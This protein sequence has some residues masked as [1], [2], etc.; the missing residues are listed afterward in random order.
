MSYFRTGILMQANKYKTFFF[1]LHRVIIVRCIEGICLL[2]LEIQ[3]SPLS[4][5]IFRALHPTSYAGISRPQTLVQPRHSLASHIH[6]NSLFPITFTQ[7]FNPC[8]TLPS[9]RKPSRSIST[10]LYFIAFEFPRSQQQASFRVP[11]DLA[12]EDDLS[13][14][15]KP[16]ELVSNS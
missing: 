12:K 4:F 16:I 2:L 11:G 13:K 6:E 10:N 8:L 9:E 1:F 3:C 15:I 14:E 7:Y 5:Q